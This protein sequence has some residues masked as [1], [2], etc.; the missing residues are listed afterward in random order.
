MDLGMDVIHD[1][2]RK[3][4][5]AE[6]FALARTHAGTQE[7]IDRILQQEARYLETIEPVIQFVQGK[8][9]TLAYRIATG[10]YLPTGARFDQL[11]DFQEAF[12]QLGVMDRAKFECTL[13][14]EDLADFIQATIDPHFGFSR[15]AERI[16]RS[17]YTFDDLYAEVQRT[18]SYVTQ[19][20]F[21]RLHAYMKEVQPKLVVFSLPFPG[22]VLAALQGAAYLR[23]HFPDVRI[24]LGGGFVNTELRSLQ[25]PRLFEWVDYVCLDDGELPLEQI[26]KHVQGEINELGLKRTFTI[27]ENS[28]I[29][30]NSCLQRDYHQREVG[31]PDYTDLHLTNYLSVLEV[32]NPMNRLWNDGRWNKLTMAHGCYWGKCT[33]CDIH[34]DYIGNYEPNQARLIVDRME[35]LML[36]TGESGFH[37][38]DEAAPPALMREVA[39]EI[40][41]RKLS[42]TWWT[43]IRFEKSFTADLCHLLQHSGCVGVSGGLEVASDRLLKLIDKGIS[44]EQVTRVLKHF[45]DA[46]IMVHA[47]L[48][49]GYPTQTVQETMDS[50][51]VVRQLFETG[52]LKSGFWHQFALTVHSPIGKNPRAFGIT[53]DPTA[54]GPFAN[55]DLRYTED[56]VVD[57]DRF[58]FGLKKS[59]FNFMHGT[60]LHQPLSYWFDFPVPKT[61]MEASFIE[62]YLQAERLPS[63]SDNQR[64]VW[65]ADPPRSERIK[66]TKKGRSWNQLNFSWTYASQLHT[67]TLED[68]QGLW[69]QQTLFAMREN[70]EFI[71]YKDWKASFELAFP[72]DDVE[73][74]FYNKLWKF[75]HGKGMVIV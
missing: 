67:C 16:A 48:M 2:F 41:Q 43:N 8:N 55:N 35:E 52:V 24:A 60:M 22:N 74:F 19:T 31:T 18:P 29:Y 71:R 65:L 56:V 26:W 72:D 54:T 17:A 11:P 73:L 20:M 66:K 46:N 28:V 47:Y 32:L 75:L 69:L 58:S 30:N 3:K 50:L 45:H 42:V 1:L 5:L 33:F 34:L 36:Q 27:K 13:Y 49:Y 61:T 62:N 63:Y 37:F 38:V 51:E 12:G 9:P 14:L 68:E 40:I 23:L 10:R 57:H 53:I 44:L 59:L 64:V 39:L 7:N 25:E 21:L 15:Y 70:E 4:S 6:M